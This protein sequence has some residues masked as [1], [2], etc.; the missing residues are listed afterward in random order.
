MSKKTDSI[1]ELTAEQVLDWLKTHPD[2]VA[3]QSEMLSSL[4]PT[5]SEPDGKVLD[6]QGF[7]VGKLRSQ[8][9][10][11]RNEIADLVTSSRDNHSIQTQVHQAVL[12]LVATRNLEQL[13]DVLTT[14]LVSR[15][16]VDVV[17]LGLESPVA[18]AYEVQYHE[19]N[20]SGICFLP[21]GM[22]DDVLGRQK[23][24]R[25]VAD[26]RKTPIIGFDEI[27]AEC[28]GIV[29]SAAMLRL[30]LPKTKRYGLI[31][32]GVKEA[33]W[34]HPRQ[35]VELLIFLARVLEL[36]LDEGLR[37]SGIEELLE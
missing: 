34:F 13:V 12:S 32:F 22:T 18:E 9:K 31:A 7:M 19:Q 23:R 27:F 21:I 15:F 16:G 35:G 33:G 5:Q 14:D 28:S 24:A 36:R 20:Y 26:V 4:L 25:L 6:L 8:I 11:Q 29:R 3:E 10:E 37:S 2:F 17:R 30:Q 1:A